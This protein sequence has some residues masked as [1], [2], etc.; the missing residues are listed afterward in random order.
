M[1]WRG[2]GI[3][4]VAV[5]ASLSFL[6]G[7]SCTAQQ[8]DPI[9]RTE[10]LVRRLAP[11]HADPCDGP[12]D[13]ISDYYGLEFKVRDAAQ[14][15]IAMRLNDPSLASETPQARAQIA[16]R[17]LEAVST[18]I[19][20][21]WPSE[22]RLD[23]QILDL[24]PALILEWSIRSRSGYIAFGI[25]TQDNPKKE[26]REIGEDD[27]SL[28]DAPTW[29]D[30]TLY[31]LHR[32]PSDHARFLAVSHSGGCAGSYGIQY[33]A[34]EL[35]PSGYGGF[36]QIIKQ[37]GACGLEDGCSG[38]KLTSKDP[39]SPIG[40]LQTH[41]PLIAL[42]YCE[43]TAIDSWDNPSLCALDSYDLSGDEVRFVS[44][45]YNR[46]DLAPVAKA[47]E[48]AQQHNLAAV[49]G[50]CASPDVARKLVR[51]IPPFVSAG[52]ELEVTWVGPDRERVELGDGGYRFELKKAGD[53]WLIV[54]FRE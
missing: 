16:V 26:W 15:A 20:G 4:V 30:F 5:L 6:W 46:P 22:K 37:A 50:Y 45:A 13:P 18:K 3:A 19:N 39:F 27:Q 14:A 21:S 49:R 29:S 53:R 54:S 40:K 36:Q 24:P 34:E 8:G 9:A 31:P 1:N 7:P 52:S 11:A 47:I 25:P 38:G 44:R 32:G 51:T 35:D 28:G 33:N 2:A 43:F 42:P 12:G 10:Q 41:G 23:F 17:E 48:F